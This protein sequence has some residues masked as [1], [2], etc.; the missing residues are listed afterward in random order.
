MT[1]TEPFNPE[2][3]FY[4]AE[5][6]QTGQEGPSFP[7]ILR[8]FQGRQATLTCE[9]GERFDLIEF[10]NRWKSGEAFQKLEH[11][12]FKKLSSAFLPS[13]DQFLNAIAAQYIDATKKPPS[14]TLPKVYDRYCSLISS[15]TYTIV[16]H[17][18]VVRESDNRVASVLIE[19]ETLRFGVWD[20]TEEEFLRMMD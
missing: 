13:Q 3:K 4:Q 19:Q 6:I 12:D 17:T 20:K 10:V 5:S 11:L 18:Y 14:H 1:T 15:K 8:H 16:S 7:D 2:S 9:K